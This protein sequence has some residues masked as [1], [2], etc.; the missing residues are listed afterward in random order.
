M[1][2]AEPPR[3]L[4]TVMLCGF[5][6]QPNWP[7]YLPPPLFVSVPIVTPVEETTTVRVAEE[8]VLVAPTRRTFVA[9]LYSQRVTFTVSAEG[10]G[11][12][13]VSGFTVKVADLVTPPPET[14]IVTRVCTVTETVKM[15]KPPLVTPAGI[16]TPLFTWATAGLLLVT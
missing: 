8:L 14:E 3:A 5:T 4:L 15:L 13:G 12:G 2:D 6:D 1:H 11:G 9:V 10:R 7:E 16:I